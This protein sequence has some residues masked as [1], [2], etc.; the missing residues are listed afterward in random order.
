MRCRKP[1][2]RCRGPIMSRNVCLMCEALI[3]ALRAWM[4]LLP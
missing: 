4:T 3:T 2:S 1:A